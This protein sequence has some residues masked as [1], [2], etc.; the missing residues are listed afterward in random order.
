MNRVSGK[1]A[2]YTRCIYKKNQG[3]PHNKLCRL[4]ECDRKFNIIYAS[5]QYDD[6]SD[7]A[8]S[9]MKFEIGSSIQTNRELFD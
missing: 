9:A 2:I 3:D 1:V 7:V 6:M 5:H 4:L 8:C